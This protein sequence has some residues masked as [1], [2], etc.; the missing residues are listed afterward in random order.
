MNF[1]KIKKK[2]ILYFIILGFYLNADANL[3][4]KKGNE[5]FV[6]NSI[7]QEDKDDIETIFIQLFKIEPFA[8]TVYFDKPMSFSGLILDSDPLEKELSYVRIDE[9]LR[10]IIDPYSPSKR[11]I[12]KSWETLEKYLPYFN[13]EK[14]LLINRKFNGFDTFILINKP[15]FKETIQKQ[16]AIFKQVIGENFSAELL[17]EQIEQPNAD[18]TKLLKNNQAL[19]GILLGFGSHNSKLF[20]KREK[21]YRKRELLNC[22]KDYKKILKIQKQIDNLWQV[23][24]ARNDYYTPIFITRHQIGYSCDRNHPESLQ[25]EEKY[26]KQAIQVDVILNQK[27]WI[28]NIMLKLMEP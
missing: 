11:I 13:K 21:L 23:L 27:E 24:Q 18:L 14:Y 22:I 28:E 20:E 2:L 19:L 10:L 1:I 3:T 9:Y 16:I 8:Y 12:K 5:N 25:L 4:Q 6:F 26:E 17:L 7:S 15:I